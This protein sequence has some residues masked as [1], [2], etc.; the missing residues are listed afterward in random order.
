MS[1]F[2]MALLIL[3]TAILIA[4]SR[5]SRS[6]KKPRDSARAYDAAKVT[7]APQV[8]SKVKGLEISSV[9]LINQGTPQAALVIA[10]INQRE[11]AVMALDFVSRAGPD[12][13]GIALDGLS[14]PANPR[15]IIPPHS[16]KT[17]TWFL[18]EIFESD[19]ISLAAAIFADGKE[20]GDKES[21]DGI[22]IERK[23]SQQK[24]RAEK[25]KNGGPQ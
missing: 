2:V 21:L 15:T 5:T 3:S 7:V 20:E 6:Q 1:L 25:V 8:V 24:H 10:V 11:E 18:G 12:S 19:D 16:L 22:K 17:F 9:T 13:G 23:N 14:D 4:Y